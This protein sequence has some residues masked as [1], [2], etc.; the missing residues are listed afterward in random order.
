MLVQFIVGRY[1]SGNEETARID[2]SNESALENAK[3]NPIERSSTYK[4]H[5]IINCK[6]C[7]YNS[8]FE[9]GAHLVDRR[10]ETVKKTINRAEYN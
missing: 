7:D 8:I 6:H 5:E 9:G 2:K 10:D 3:K 1:K 4:L